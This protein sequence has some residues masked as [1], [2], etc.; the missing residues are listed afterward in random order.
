MARRILLVGAG[1]R[2]G[3]VLLQLLG[4]RPEYEVIGLLQKELDILESEQV[5]AAVERLR[6]AVI[7][8]CAGFSDILAAEKDPVGTLSVHTRGLFNLARAAERFHAYL[9]SFSSKL[10]FNGRKGALYDEAD[11]LWPLNQFGI[12]KQGGEEMVA[13]LLK[14]HLIIRSDLVYGPARND[15]V[16]RIIQAL[17]GGHV[18]Q[19]PDDF[20]VAPTY[21]GDLAAAT[22]ALLSEWAAG[23]YHYTNDAGEGVSLHAFAREVAALTGSDQG[24]LQAGP[25][26][27][28]A[29]GGLVLPARAILS[30]ERFRELFPALVRPWREALADYLE[31]LGFR[32]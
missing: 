9:C 8:D 18:L 1:G 6:P 3:R 20:F 13:G 17:Q 4:M 24:L 21:I 10:V 32:S 12:S 5:M 25:L 7:I 27:E 23:I 28:M 30:L 26:A 29:S 14:N 22:V 31:T 16:E 11:E 2:L 19:V 15:W